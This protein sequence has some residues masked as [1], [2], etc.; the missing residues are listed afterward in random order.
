MKLKGE[1]SSDLIEAAEAVMAFR[2]NEDTDE[3]LVGA[4]LTAEFMILISA[5]LR[6]PAQ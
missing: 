1:I 3:A 5:F 6:P 4:M 2:N